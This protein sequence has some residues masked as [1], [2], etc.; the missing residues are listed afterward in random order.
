ME[1][2]V[3]VIPYQVNLLCDDCGKEMVKENFVCLSDPPLYSYKCPK[4]GK[5]ITSYKNYPYIRM[6]KVNKH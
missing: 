6:K 5:V 4:C 2:K 1:Q 3:R